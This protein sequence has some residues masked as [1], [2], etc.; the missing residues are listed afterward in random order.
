LVFDD[1][2]RYIGQQ[3][4]L[5]RFIQ[6]FCLAATDYGMSVDRNPI[7]EFGNFN[8]PT[9]SIHR[10]CEA[11]YTRIQRE[12]RGAP[13]LM[14]FVIKGKSPVMY[15][16]VKAFA[17]TVR[18]VSSQVV[19]GQNVF[20]KGGDRAY[21][22]NLLLKVNIKLGGTTVSLSAPVTQANIPTVPPPAAAAL[23]PHFL[24]PPFIDCSCLLAR[25]FLMLL[26]VLKPPPLPLW[27]VASTSTACTMPA[28]CRKTKIIVKR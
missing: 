16:T 13:E 11:L 21:H 2:R 27:S 26:R 23:Q 1:K 19:N 25:T 17:D 4:I 7:V 12:K 5:T 14:M 24:L 20:T 9:E 22:A 10:D 8:A 18:G 28:H 15:E 3:S 6:T